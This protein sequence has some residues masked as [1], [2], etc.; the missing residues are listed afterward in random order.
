MGSARSGATGDPL[1]PPPPPAYHTAFDRGTALGPD[2]WN[3]NPA[4]G[5]IDLFNDAFG[6]A[7]QFGHTC[8]AAP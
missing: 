6:V 1:S 7:A 3:V 4:D 8:R 5:I 2:A